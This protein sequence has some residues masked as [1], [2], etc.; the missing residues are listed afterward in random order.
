MIHFPRSIFLVLCYLS[1]FYI[2]CSMFPGLFRV[3]RSLLS[4]L[5]S[6]FC[7]LCSFPCS[8]LLFH[9][10]YSKFHVLILRS[11]FLILCTLYVPCSLFYVLYSLLYF[12]CSSFYVPC[13]AFHFPVFLFPVLC[14]SFRLYAIVLL[15]QYCIYHGFMPVCWHK[16]RL[17][18]CVKKL[19]PR[20]TRGPERQTNRVCMLAQATQRQGRRTSSR[21]ETDKHLGVSGSL[22]PFLGGY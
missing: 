17:A 8:V 14:P 18:L 3:I 12:Q 2:P 13:S 20:H 21:A 4:F 7:V 10:R 19:L 16:I 15:S 5:C 22:L 11:L 6:L 9:V 1:P